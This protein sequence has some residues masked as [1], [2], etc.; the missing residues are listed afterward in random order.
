MDSLFF[1]VICDVVATLSYFVYTGSGL[2]GSPKGLVRWIRLWGSFESNLALPTPPYTTRKV[3]L[4]THKT[5]P[6]LITQTS[7]SPPGQTGV[8]VLIPCAVSFGVPKTSLC[9]S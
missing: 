9:H 8:C 6:L 2:P 3:R 7:F 5:H 4:V 1:L